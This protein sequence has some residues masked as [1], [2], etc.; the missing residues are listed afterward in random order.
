MRLFDGL[1]EG[2]LRTGTGEIELQAFIE[3]EREVLTVLTRNSGSAVAEWRFEGDADPQPTN[4]TRNVGPYYLGP[5][6]TSPPTTGRERGARFFSLAYAELGEPAGD[7]T[8][9]WDEQGEAGWTVRNA[10]IAYNSNRGIDTR[11]TALATLEAARALTAG[12]RLDRHTEV[13]NE[14]MTRRFVSIPDKKLESFYYIP[15]PQ[16]ARRHPPRRQPH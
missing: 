12:A 7:I 13:W 6:E 9:A 4:R 11:D 10:T 16:A 15:V 5:Y 1:L 14:F 3:A 2:T 8:V